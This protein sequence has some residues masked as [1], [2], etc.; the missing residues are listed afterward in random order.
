MLAPAGALADEL[1]LR[2]A[3]SRHQALERR[4]GGHDLRAA[5]LGHGG[6]LVAEDAGVS[7]LVGGDRARDPHVVEEPGEDPH[8]V[9]GARILAIRLDAVEAGLGADARDLELGHERRRL[10]AEPL[11]VGDGALGREEREA[12]QILDV[13]LVEDDEPARP[14]PGDE[15]VQP[16]PPFAELVRADAGGDG[17]GATIVGRAR[18][19]AVCRR[20]SSSST[21]DGCN[22]RAARRT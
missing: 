19:A 11:H 1:D 7:I 15:R 3:L 16:L 6:P 17:D 18:Q 8:G 14:L 2:L 10:A 9:L 12:R 13:A 21:A 22:P 5:D 20:R 4:R